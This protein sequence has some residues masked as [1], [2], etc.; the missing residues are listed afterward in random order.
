MKPDTGRDY[1]DAVTLASVAISEQSA[2]R[3]GM[4]HPK[5]T[6]GQLCEI[7]PSFKDAW[8]KEGAPPDDG[9][10]DGVYYKWTHHHIMS[11]FL[12][13][14]SVCHHSFNEQQLRQFG[15]WVNSAATSDDDLEN[16]VSTCFLEHSRQ[17]SINR[18]LAPYLSLRAKAKQH[19]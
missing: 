11:A 18:V 16:A 6:L 14:F 12:D 4:Q 8:D 1:I 15:N 13:Y 3:A 7:F 10:V 17:V 5:D 9:L 19:P 2:K